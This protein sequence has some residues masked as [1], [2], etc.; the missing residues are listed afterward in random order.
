M[1]TNR[2][3]RIPDLP[4]RWTVT[5]LNSSV[6]V[7]KRVK[8]NDD[9]A[10]TGTEIRGQQLELLRNGGPSDLEPNQLDTFLNSGTSEH[11]A[12]SNEGGND[13]QALRYK[14]RRQKKPISERYRKS[15][16]PRSTTAVVRMKDTSAM[17]EN[18]MVIGFDMKSEDKKQ[19]KPIMIR[20]V[21]RGRI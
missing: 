18:M 20:N 13:G 15:N 9:R 21:G 8:N 14:A 10:S 7:N 2:A 5:I 11:D 19:S 1:K 3:A 4:Q 17:A 16:L 12:A 6:A